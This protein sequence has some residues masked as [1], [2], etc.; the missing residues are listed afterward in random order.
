MMNIK[1]QL[2]TILI[3][4]LFGIFFSLQLSINYKFI[5]SNKKIYKIIFTFLIVL[6]NTLLYFILLKKFNNGILHVYGIICII[7]G[8][9]V[10]IFV[11]TLVV[12]KIH[13]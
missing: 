2:I 3:S 9:I 8:F 1:T 13:R 5:Y 11:K 10:E 4:F 7:I 6:V 12:K